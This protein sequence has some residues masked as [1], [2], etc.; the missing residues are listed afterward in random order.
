MIETKRLIIRPFVPTDAKRVY[1][2]CNDYEVVKTTLGIPWPYSEKMAES[3]IGRKAEEAKNGSSYEYAICLKE[4]VNNIVGCI[5][6]MGTDSA[7]K[8]AELGYWLERKLWGQGIATE[9]AKAMIEFGFNKLGL[10]SIYARFFD[11]NPASGR[12]MEKCG[13][14]YAG[15][16]RKHE[17]RFDQYYNI[18]FYET[19]KEDNMEK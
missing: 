15:M 6:L 8:K 4:D 3:W 7:A 13:M 5:S 14:T 1:E 2:C 11:I 9:A 19:L 17:F 12:V 16:L 10:N 18:K